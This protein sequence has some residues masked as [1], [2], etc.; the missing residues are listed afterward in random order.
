MNIEIFTGW[1]SVFEDADGFK[2]VLACFE[3]DLIH[4]RNGNT[5]HV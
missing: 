2:V 1:V 4:S 5:L 3:E